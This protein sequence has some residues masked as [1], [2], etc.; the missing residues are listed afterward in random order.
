M[1]SL[2]G[3]VRNKRAKGI[4]KVDV[5]GAFAMGSLILDKMLRSTK[6]SNRGM[7]R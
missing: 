7:L 4:P 1:M 6:N 5:L 3:N 2:N